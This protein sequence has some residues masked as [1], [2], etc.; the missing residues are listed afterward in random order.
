MNKCLFILAAYINHSIINCLEIE[1]PTKALH[2]ALIWSNYK[3][4]NTLKYL[5][6]STPDGLINFIS[7]GFGGRITD[8]EIIEATNFLNIL[9]NNCGWNRLDDDDDE[10]LLTEKYCQLD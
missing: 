8:K 3:K 9:P 6:S 10:L 4:T 5:I 7:E 2:Q 1:I